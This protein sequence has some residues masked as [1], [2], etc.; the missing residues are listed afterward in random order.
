MNLRRFKGTNEVKCD[1]GKMIVIGEKEIRKE[2]SDL[3]YIRNIHKVRQFTK[4]ES[5][6]IP[7]HR[8]AEE[9]Y[10]GQNTWIQRR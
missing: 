9:L 3:S 1:L 10:E 8:T 4:Y 7:P 5:H 2:N 6:M